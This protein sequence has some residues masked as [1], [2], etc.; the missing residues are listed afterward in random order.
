M[1]LIMGVMYH[2]PLQHLLDEPHRIAED[3]I[4]RLAGVDLASIPAYG[5]NVII[6][7]LIVSSLSQC[8]C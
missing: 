1:R 6:F 2:F 8:V 4:R 5:E 7:A 3:V